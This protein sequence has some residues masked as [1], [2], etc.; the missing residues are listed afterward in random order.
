[1][2]TMIVNTYNKSTADRAGGKSRVA[3]AMFAEAMQ[4]LDDAAR[5]PFGRPKLSV[6]VMA[7]WGG[8]NLMSVI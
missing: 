7:V 3:I 1:M 2:S 8:Q 5:L 4:N 6:N